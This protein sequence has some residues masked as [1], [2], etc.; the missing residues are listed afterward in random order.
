V[1]MSSD[2]RAWRFT[3]AENLTRLMLG[4]PEGWRLHTSKRVLVTGAFFERVTYR[5]HLL[6]GLSLEPHDGRTWWHLSMSGRDRV[7][8]WADLVAAKEAFLGTDS[9]AIQVIPRRARYVNVHPNCLHLF[10]PATG[11]TGLPDFSWTV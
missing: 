6:L 3:P 11:E 8:T 5:E 7:P 1:S 10:A 2:E 9:D 4:P